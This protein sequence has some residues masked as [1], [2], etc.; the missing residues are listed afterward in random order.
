MVCYKPH[1][2]FPEN[3]KKLPLPTPW[4]YLKTSGKNSRS[5]ERG[6]YVI[7]GNKN[8]LQNIVKHWLEEEHWHELVQDVVQR[9][10]EIHKEI[11]WYQR[12]AILKKKKVKMKWNKIKIEC[13][14]S[15]MWSVLHF[16]TP[17]EQKTVRFSDVF[18]GYGNAK[19]AKNGLRDVKAAKEVHNC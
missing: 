19:L 4:K 6:F 11:F 1:F 2:V 8:V 15:W 3:I 10:V 18:R 14:W 17:W 9:S 5:R 13:C 16:S 7:R 12:G